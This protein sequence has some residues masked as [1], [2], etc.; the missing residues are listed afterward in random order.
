MNSTR[1][2]LTL[3]TASL[4]FPLPAVHGVDDT[5]PLVGAIRRDGRYGEGDVVKQTKAWLGE[6]A[7]LANSLRNLFERGLGHAPI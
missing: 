6:M 5:R 7:P 1:P 3:V 4:L 2:I